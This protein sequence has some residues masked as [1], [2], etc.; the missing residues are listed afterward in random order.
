MVAADADMA[1]LRR[2]VGVLRRRETRRNFDMQVVVGLIRGEETERTG[3]VVRAQDLM[4]L[5]HGL[6]VDVLT[7]LLE[8]TP[9]SWDT[10]WLVRPGVPAAHDA[11]L[12]WLTAARD[13]FAAHGRALR[14]F[15][16]I[17]RYGWL[18][19]GDGTSRFWKRLRT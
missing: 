14:G 2:E 1:W 6:R 8:E 12:A 7:A 16:A 5:D 11:D 19:L 13:A 10:S 4:L 15:F 18:D 3:F 9:G 17:T